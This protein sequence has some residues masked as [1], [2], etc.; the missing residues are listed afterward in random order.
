MD[1]NAN[2]EIVTMSDDGKEE[3][4]KSDKKSSDKKTV[5]DEEAEEENTKDDDE[6]GNDGDEDGDDEDDDD[7]SELVIDE[8]VKSHEKKSRDR[9]RRVKS[10]Q[11]GDKKDVERE[12]DS[13]SSTPRLP[14]TT[15]EDMEGVPEGWKRKISQRMTG[16]SAG[17]FDVYIFSPEGRKFRSRPEL[18]AYIEE[19][20]LDYTI[21]DFNFKYKGSPGSSSVVRR[22]KPTPTKKA[23]TPVKRPLLE[24]S[25]SAKSKRRKKSKSSTKRSHAAATKGPRRV[26]QPPP[27]SKKDKASRS[28][29]FQK[30]LVKMNFQKPGERLNTSSSSESDSD[31]D[32]DDGMV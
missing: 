11:N 22:T 17:K 28:Q 1:E 14:C 3:K 24:K 29:A 25:D 12:K 5:S 8:K 20:S 9:K 6:D 15:V 10:K 23:K 18:M 30:L 7:G 16:K 32:F 4:S 13:K 19:N 27:E 26:L 31:D 21:D 2:S